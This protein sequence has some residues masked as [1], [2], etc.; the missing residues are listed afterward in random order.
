M[1]TLLQQQKVKLVEGA[2]CERESLLPMVLFWCTKT[3][4]ATCWVAQQLRGPLEWNLR[5]GEMGLG[6]ELKE[7]GKEIGQKRK[8]KSRGFIIK[9]FLQNLHES[10]VLDSQK[11]NGAWE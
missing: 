8:R 1:C 9:S 10:T 3:C 2:A 6:Q 5:R 4:A 11:I 7:K